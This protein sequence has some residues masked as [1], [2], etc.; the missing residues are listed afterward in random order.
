MYAEKI[1]W[2]ISHQIFFF[3]KIPVSGKNG[4]LIKVCFQKK[5]FMFNKVFFR[6]KVM[7]TKVFFL[8]KNFVKHKFFFWKTNFYE[9]TVFSAHWDLCEKKIWWALHSTN[10][11]SFSLE[12]KVFWATLFFAHFNLF[13][14]WKTLRMEVLSF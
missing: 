12:N 9:P 7:L 3:A 8:K 14:S 2:T 4:W 11:F 1:G 10:L 6:K 5:K 13:K